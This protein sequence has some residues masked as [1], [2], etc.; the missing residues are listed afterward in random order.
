[1]SI[2]LELSNII[3]NN[4]DNKEDIL[5]CR[6][7]SRD[8]LSLTT[9]RVFR[10]LN[11]NG[12]DRQS[13]SAIIELANTPDIAEH[14]RVIVYRHNDDDDDEDMV[15]M[16]AS[17][18]S[19]LGKF[20]LLESIRFYFPNTYVEWGPDEMS[21][22]RRTQISIFESIATNPP[23]ISLHELEIHSLLALPNP[24]FRLPGFAD[25]LKPLKKLV[26]KTNSDDSGE[27]V[28]CDESYMDFWK[29]DV[30]RL[31]MSPA[32]L[33]SITLDSD[34][35]CDGPYSVWDAVTFPDLTS[36][37]LGMIVL[38]NNQN[39]GVEKFISRHGS[40][41]VTLELMSCPADVDQENPNP[42]ARK[43]S[44]IW[45]RF[46]QTLPRLNTFI[47]DPMPGRPQE[48][49]SARDG[50]DYRGYAYFMI[51]S[52]YISLFDDPPQDEDVDRM[53][54]EHLQDVIR[55]R[56]DLE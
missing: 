40:T 4:V 7:V 32:A 37:H 41:L 47:F 49:A 2:P 30:A 33:T 14:V 23:P 52:G 29:T 34:L 19:H 26:I 31:L 22:D 11:I 39:I 46:E 1:M 50:E 51:E 17:S 24:A 3:I 35:Y 55:A 5:A 43:W 16:A 56:Q 27:S 25:F 20:A 44:D 13:T 8:F 42:H 54:F 18:L 12:G 15:A 10:V 9:P 48:G 21:T 6:L 53:A 28:Y 45:A 38:N 36:L